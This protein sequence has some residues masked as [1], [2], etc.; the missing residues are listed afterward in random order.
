MRRCVTYWY[1]WFKVKYLGGL[2]GIGTYLQ[3]KNY[4]HMHY[5]TYV[6]T[7]LGMYDIEQNTTKK[8]ATKLTVKST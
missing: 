3:S 1:L 5:I 7:I 6:G 2:A 4:V 8:L